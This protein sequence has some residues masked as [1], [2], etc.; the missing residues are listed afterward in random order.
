VDQRAPVGYGPISRV[1]PEPGGD[2]T[3]EKL[4]IDANS[5]LQDSFRL[6]RLVLDSGFQPTHIVGIWRGGAPVGIAV[7]ELLEYHGVESDH[8]AIRTSSYRGIDVMAPQ[9][10]VYSLSYLVQVLDPEHRLLIVDDVFDSGRSIEA[11]ITKLQQR[12]RNNMA[13]EVRV[14]TVY[15]KPLRN[16]TTLAPDFYVHE[17]ESWLVFPHELK[18]LTP[19]EIRQHKMPADIILG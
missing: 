4:F 17:T 18:G 6:G 5:L 19:E 2:V 3:A 10:R 14:A 8:I 1:L 15:Y 13:R 11:L 12:C 16:R 9:V 7:Q